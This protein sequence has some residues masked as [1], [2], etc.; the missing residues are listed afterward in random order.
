[1]RGARLFA[2]LVM[3]GVAA[4]VERTGPTAP[5]EVVRMADGTE[6]I[7]IT[8]GWFTMGSDTEQRREMARLAATRRFD[9]DEMTDRYAELYRE[10]LEGG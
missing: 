5:P 2:C 8:G 7:R 4:C 3:L 1:M 6:M 10:L 9:V